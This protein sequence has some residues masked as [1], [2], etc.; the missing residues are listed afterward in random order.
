MGKVSF[1]ALYVNIYGDIIVGI[2]YNRWFR[3]KLQVESQ[4]QEFGVFNFAVLMLIL[5]T[6]Y[7]NIS[8]VYWILTLNK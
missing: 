6:S 1:P 5:S 7:T 8:I 3:E 2:T 4:V